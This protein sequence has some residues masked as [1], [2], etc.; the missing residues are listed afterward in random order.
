MALPPISS[1]R[2]PSLTKC[3]IYVRVSTRDKG[4]SVDNQLN[5]LLDFCDR[6]GWQVHHIYREERSGTGK[7]GR[8]V[9]DQL[10]SD[11]SKKLFDVVL[12]WS[13]DRFSR[14]GIGKTVQH[15]RRLESYGINFKSYTEE[16]LDTDNELVRHI[17]LGVLAHMAKHEATR[18]KER[19]Y[20]GLD[21]AKKEGK[22][23]GRPS[24]QEYW[25]PIIIREL[26]AGN[27]MGYIHRT[28][29]VSKNT[30]KKYLKDSGNYPYKR[31]QLTLSDIES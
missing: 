1:S 2:N 9:F 7:Q 19:I 30:I 22:T 27:S 24:K 4:Q 31:K 13:L 28:H 18:L 20:A 15:L 26:E 25:L 17:L 23:F 21:R 14:E 8:P 16:Y 29:G 10:M 6:K 3:A 5:P 12:F 11:A